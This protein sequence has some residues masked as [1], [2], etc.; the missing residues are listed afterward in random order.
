MF[1][2]TNNILHNIFTFKLN[3]RNILQKNVS[4]RNILHD[5]VNPVERFYGSE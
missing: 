5:V 4:V 1:R 3:V 2:E